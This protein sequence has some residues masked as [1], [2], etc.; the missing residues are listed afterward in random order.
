MNSFDADTLL[1]RCRALTPARTAIVHAV[2]S[3]TPLVL[4]GPS[5]AADIAR[6]LP[7][8]LTLACAA[9]DEQRAAR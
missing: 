5:F 6:G 4:T 1:T 2:S 9:A 8:A 7:T 3:A